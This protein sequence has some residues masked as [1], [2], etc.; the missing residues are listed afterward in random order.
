MGQSADLYVRKGR[1]PTK[2]H[3][4]CLPILIWKEN[5]SSVLFAC[6]QTSPQQGN[7]RRLHA[8]NSAVWCR[9]KVR[10]IRGGGGQSR[11]PKARAAWG[12]RGHAPP[13][14]FEL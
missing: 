9:S 10:F 4:K 12:V 11:A 6:V 13:E 1:P 8:G 7:R 5:Q 2:K 14:D 3:P